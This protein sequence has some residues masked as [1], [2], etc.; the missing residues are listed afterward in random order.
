MS[1]RG[2]FFD[3]IEEYSQFWQACNWYTYRVAMFEF[4]D[5]RIMG[6]VEMTLIVLGLGFRVR[7]NYHVTEEVA[8]IKRQAAELDAM[9]EEERAKLPTLDEVMDP[10]RK[11]EN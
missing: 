5:D 11:R 9:T 1:Y 8:K 3:F 2:V 4:E 7:W 6:G 10:S